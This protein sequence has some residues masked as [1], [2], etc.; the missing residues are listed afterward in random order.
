MP[1][2]KPVSVRDAALPVSDVRTPARKGIYNV[3]PIAITTNRRPWMTKID[4]SKFEGSCRV[5]M[6][7]EEIIDLLVP[8]ARELES[9]NQRL[10]EA[11]AFYA[12][13]SPH[14]DTAKKRRWR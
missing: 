13:N 9:E 7:Y 2:G 6:S 8:Y 1:C 3:A 5:D 14:S 4:L 11:L 10:L 12:E